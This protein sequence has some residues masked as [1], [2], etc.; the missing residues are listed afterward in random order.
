[1]RD[2][3]STKEREA[4]EERMWALQQEANRLMMM[5]NEQELAAK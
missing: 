3:K 2:N 5:Q 1:V 4:E